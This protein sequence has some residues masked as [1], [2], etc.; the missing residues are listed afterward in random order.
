M[1][2]K[3]KYVQDE[4][5]KNEIKLTLI[6]SNSMMVDPLTKNIS[7]PNINTLPISS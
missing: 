5:T 3:Y 6:G 2:I 7:G 1:D 4:I